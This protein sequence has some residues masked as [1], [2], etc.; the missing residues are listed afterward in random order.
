MEQNTDKPIQQ[1]VHQD[2]KHGRLCLKSQLLRGAEKIWRMVDLGQTQQKVRET[3]SQLVAGHGGAHLS[4]Q[5]C[6]KHK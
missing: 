5:L 2:T 4:S 1:N 3:L 6:K